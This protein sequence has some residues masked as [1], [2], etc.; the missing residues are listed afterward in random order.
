MANDILVATEG[1]LVTFDGQER[2]IKPGDTVRVGH[3]ILDGREDL[4]VPLR[5]TF[6]LE[7]PVEE[8]KPVEASKHVAHPKSKTSDDATV[9]PEAT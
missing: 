2:V 7:A 6:E 1:R 4:F 8:V 3:P 5:P 9:K